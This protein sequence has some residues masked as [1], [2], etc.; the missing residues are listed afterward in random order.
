MGVKTAVYKRSLSEKIFLV[1][2]APAVIV[3]FGIYKY[4]ETLVRVGA[5]KD[6]SSLYFLGK[7][8]SF[9]YSFIYTCVVCG[10]AL[11]VIASGKSP[12]KKMKKAEL[13]SYQRWK[14][15][16]IFT[17]QLLFFF[18]IPYII[19][20]LMR[21]GPF[22]AD[23]V[24]PLN[25]NAFIYVSRG[26]TSWG[27]FLYIFILVPALVM[28]F[29]KRYCSWFCACGNLAETIG[30]TKWGSNW[31]RT[32]TPRSGTAKR[33]EHLQTAFLA[34]GIL[35]G[36][37]M[38][39]DIATLFSSKTLLEA[40]MLY[41]NVVVDL[42]FGAFIGLGAYP[43]FGTRIWC[44]YG[45][46]LARLMELTGRYGKSRFTVSAND[47]CKG[48]D[49]CTQT[50]PMGVPVSSYAHK[51]KKPILGSFGLGE[52]PCIG[53]GGCIDRCPMD[54][55]SFGPPSGAVIESAGEKVTS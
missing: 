48:L 36:F 54:A 32:K 11:K 28:F 23:P 22:F 44:R 29:G 37:V 51:D 34:L 53:C 26:F 41:Q 38:F 47:N 4:P 50:C 20:G 14:F 42:V 40:G 43:F 24:V 39:L 3:G 25:K 33:M 46:P 9:W 52:T 10:I 35:Y 12:Y 1:F 5:I 16:S 27:G 13:G 19:P 30:V 21:D 6:V 31:V 2:F 8:P 17:A 7:H 49:L 18:I 15:T 55:L 45:C